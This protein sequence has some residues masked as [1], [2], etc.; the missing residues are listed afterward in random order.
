MQA[1]TL[2]LDTPRYQ[3]VQWALI[4]LVLLTGPL[5]PAFHGMVNGVAQGAATPFAIWFASA[6]CVSALQLGPML[7]MSNNREGLLHPLVIAALLWPM[8]IQLATIVETVFGALEGFDKGLLRATQYAALSEYTQYDVWLA[9][10]KFN[11]VICLSLACL[12]FGYFLANNRLSDRQDMQRVLR[13]TEQFRLLVLT[14]CGLVLVGLAVFLSFQGGILSHLASLSEGRARALEGLGPV[15]VAFD[16]GV[17]AVMLWLAWRPKAA[18]NPLFIATLLAMVLVQFISNGSRSSALL[19]VA[20][21]ALTWALVTRRLPQRIA[22]IAVPIGLFLLFA[23][24]IVRSSG[25][26]G[27]TAFEALSQMEVSAVTERMSTEIAGRK[28]LSGAVPIVAESERFGGPL[29]GETYLAAI[30]AWV[31]RP[32]WPDK[33]R[34]AGSQFTQTAYNTD[35]DG[36]AVPIPATAESYWNFGFI[37]V[38]LLHLLHGFLL[39]R[40]YVFWKRWSLDPFVTTGFVLFVTQFSFATDSIVP[41]MQKTAGLVLLFGIASMLGMRVVQSVPVR[42]RSSGPGS[43]SPRARKAVRRLSLEQRRS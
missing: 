40:A 7:T 21:V 35:R 16:L 29:W 13:Y 30:F 26:Y 1:S 24:A 20:S 2:H 18:A 36:F 34:G 3:G 15:V 43:P 32:V 10:A 14:I 17:V 33:P 6:L 12:Y 39:A 22:V 11:V 19:A 25:S 8:I 23:L 42:T 37:G 5:I 9:E 38:G 31:P 28:Y 41:W 27:Q 4:V